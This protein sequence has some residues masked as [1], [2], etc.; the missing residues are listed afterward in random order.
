MAGTR[1][2]RSVPLAS[3]VTSLPTTIREMLVARA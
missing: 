1:V 2:R 3:V